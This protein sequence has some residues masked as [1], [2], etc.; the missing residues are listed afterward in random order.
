MPR[1]PRP[2]LPHRL[3]RC[4]LLLVT[5]MLVV[6]SAAT[7]TPAA[8]ATT[9]GDPL[10]R[11]PR[12]TAESR[13]GYAAR[14]DAVIRQFA[15]EPLIAPDGDGEE[16]FANILTAKL[17]AVRRAAQRGGK[18]QCAK[19]T[20][21]GAE[22]R[23]EVN[24]TLLAMKVTS[25][26]GTEFEVVPGVC[27]RSGEWDVVMRGLIV[28][29]Y[30]YGQYLDGEVHER[31]LAKDPLLH[32]RGKAHDGMA[33]WSCKLPP[34]GPKVHIPESENHIL[35][36]R[37]SHYLTNQLL[38][39]RQPGDAAFDNKANGMRDWMLG[40]L[41]RLLRDDFIEYNSRPYQDYSM[42]ALQ[43]LYDFAADDDVKRAAQMVLDYTSAKF[44][45][46]SRGLRR[47]V[48]F[49]RLRGDD[50]DKLHDPQTWR[51]LVLVGSS[52]TF[53]WS[54]PAADTMVPAAL[55]GYRVPDLITDLI[56]HPT[57][58]FQRFRHAGAEV[59]SGSEE[60]LIS[61]GGVVTPHAYKNPVSALLKPDDKGKAVPTLL[62][63]TRAGVGSRAEVVRIDGVR[64]H[65]DRANVC[66]EPNFA[67]GVNI[68]VPA[69]GGHICGTRVVDRW[70]FVDA[71]LPCRGG[72]AGYYA[73]VRIDRCGESEA[74][75]CES[76]GVGNGG[77]FEAVPATRMPFDAF[78]D[79]VLRNNPGPFRAMTGGR[80]VTTDGRQIDYKPLVK[81]KDVAPGALATGD[82]VTSDAH[83]GLVTVRNPRTGQV[84]V[85]DFTVANRP[86]RH[87]RSGERAGTPFS[88][89]PG[90]TPTAAHQAGGQL[91]LFVVGR[92]GVPT[93]T[94]QHG[95]AWRPWTPVV[96]GSRFTAPPGAP[97][98]TAMQGEQL[99]A[100]VVGR[101][102]VPMMTWLKAKTW[103]PWVPV[104][105]GSR[106]TAPPGAP[107]TTG[108]QGQQLNAFVVGHEG[109][110]M[111]TWLKGGAWQPWVPVVGGSRF[112][113]PAGAPIT[114]GTQGAQLNAFVVG[115]DGVPMMT[116]IKGKTW[117]PWVRVSADSR[118]RAEP[119]A[120]ITAATRSGRPI[121]FAVDRAGAPHVTWLRNDGWQ[122]WVPV[123]AG[124]TAP[125]R[126]RLAAA[127]QG[128]T[129][130]DLFAV[131]N[132]G[133][134][135]VSWTTGDA[136]V[137]WA[138]VSRLPLG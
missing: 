91:D 117:Q 46:S 7:V 115:Q 30:R 20:A 136:W 64:D 47:N 43:T 41:Q 135:A 55:T 77:F 38:Q 118:F 12:N 75:A 131:G 3:K 125:P 138:P 50:I 60:F 9:A 16:S 68:E 56:L 123:A 45:V 134:P 36:T 78:V 114:T 97:I 101:D 70:T 73:A 82:I 29:A 84:L 102:G 103:Q 27:K 5:A 11:A 59:Y 72:G 133:V 119:G 15:C 42:A 6:T 25:N 95:N 137:P 83:T 52:D 14:S 116:W 98:A 63:P 8:A 13:A 48:P 80:Y 87:E 112:T 4:G 57:G 10:D 108:M 33:R 105:G 26:P 53:G 22:L 99:N 37:T 128:R 19:G 62:I 18:Y 122:P 86:Q 93:M 69:A 74:L 81:P 1:E 79:L 110:P 67:C 34:V 100:F 31:L 89:S 44:A 49:R 71:H 121:L 111:M 24:R 39:R 96:G 40:Y 109:V 28:A 76:R 32:V 23:A 120:P 126:A 94:W 90:A 107:I 88:V 85:L 17:E 129:Q 54:V 51:H 127:D 104:V 92:D 65:D 113:V 61:A 2:T 130:L 21:D 66:V 106:F 124:M 58:Y 35:L 132:D